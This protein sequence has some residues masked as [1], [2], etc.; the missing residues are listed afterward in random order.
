VIL[1]DTSAWVEHFRGD[2][3]ADRLAGLLE[4]DE[5]LLHPW[6][7]GELALGGLGP[8]RAEVIADLRRLPAAPEIPHSEVLDLI[9]DRRLAGVGIGWVDAHLLASALVVRGGL[10]T[11]DT[12]LSRVARELGVPTGS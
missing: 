5:V 7:L 11:L 12:R 8:H 4:E 6:V 9:L 1:V 10:W 2:P 3:R